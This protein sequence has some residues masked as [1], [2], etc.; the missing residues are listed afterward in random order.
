MHSWNRLGP[1]GPDDVVRYQRTFPDG[2]DVI[3]TIRNVGGA[4]H[5]T[6]DAESRTS[7]PAEASHGS[8]ATLAEAMERLEEEAAAWERDL[9]GS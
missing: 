1:S 2:T 8:F 7:G 3:L 4:Y 9:T 6:S 5:V